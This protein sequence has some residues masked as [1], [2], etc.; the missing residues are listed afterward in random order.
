VYLQDYAVYVN[1]VEHIILD[2]L[3]FMLSRNGNSRKGAGSL[4][5]DKFDAQDLAL[6]KFRKFATERLVRVHAAKVF[7]SYALLCCSTL[8]CSS[9]LYAITGSDL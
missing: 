4:S 8:P 9:V 7:C 6:E 3:Q 5:W 1:D 2:N